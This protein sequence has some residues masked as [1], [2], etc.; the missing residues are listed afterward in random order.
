MSE[1][2]GSRAVDSESLVLVDESDRDVGHLSKLRCHEGRG[3]LHR[4][5][6]LFVFNDD[7]ELLIQQRSEAKRLWPLYWSNSCCSHPRSDETMERATTRRL[8]EELGLDCPLRFL[9]KFQYQAQF[10][11]TG[12]ENELCSVFIGKSSDSVKINRDEIQAI[13]WVRPEQFASE[14]SGSEAGGFTPWLRLEWPRLWRDHR[15]EVLDLQ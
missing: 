14:L 4:A 9:F 2:D 12:A 3:I 7:G 6:S 15:A 11:E 5:F 8:R 1:I 13:R 10:D